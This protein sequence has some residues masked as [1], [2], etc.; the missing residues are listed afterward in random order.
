MVSEDARRLTRDVPAAVRDDAR[1]PTRRVPATVRNDAGRPTRHVPA[2]VRDDRGQATVEFVAV[3]PLVAAL[4]AALWQLA[5]VGYAEWAAS[6]A[7]R[8]AA[9]A[10]AVGADP[11]GA[12][13]AHLAR[14]LES[15]L[16]VRSLSRGAVRVAVRIPT[17]PGLP[18]LGHA[19]ATG[20]F[21]PQS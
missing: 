7:A 10:D 12:A 4:L 15:G 2:T 21:E 18:G 16:R 8:A 14:S 3:L 13:R 1:Q 5:L 19:R 6:A 17:L 9:R 20:H 11:A